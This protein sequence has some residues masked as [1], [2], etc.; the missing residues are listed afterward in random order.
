MSLPT[1]VSWL[2]R[3]SWLSCC[4]ALTLALYVWLMFLKPGGEGW[5]R[6]WNMVAFF[7]YA[8][9]AALACG[10]IAFWRRTKLTGV[11]RALATAAGIAG[12]A[13]PVVCLVAIRL[14]A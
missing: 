12:L 9:P 4:A 7:L 1:L 11:A 10:A 5:G 13:F 8:A 6:G 14:K 3:D 2:R